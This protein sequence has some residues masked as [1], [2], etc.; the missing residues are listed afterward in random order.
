VEQATHFRIPP[1]LAEKSQLGAALNSA[2]E[3]PAQQREF[4]QSAYD[5]ALAVYLNNFATQ[6]EVNKALEELRAAI[7]HFTAR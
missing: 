2:Q 7:I 1:G 4:I 5:V 6:M 3:V